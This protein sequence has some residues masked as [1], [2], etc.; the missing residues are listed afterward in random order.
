[1]ISMNF[2]YV[3]LAA[4]IPIFVGAVWYAKPVFGNAWM[5]AAGVTDEKVKG[6]HMAIIFV[7]AY[8]LS[9]MI[10]FAMVPITIHQMGVFSVLANEP[11]IED[12]NSPVGAYLTDFMVKY[13]KNFRT[14]KHGA[15]HGTITAIFF[16]LPVIGTLALFERKSFKY[17]AIHTGYW[18]VSLALVG[19]VVCAFV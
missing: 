3:V 7:L 14:F 1:M 9:L 10:S 11:G 19:G 12:P 17:V 18:I 6:A 16:A 4:L 13:G 15:F 5:K 8:I 2:I